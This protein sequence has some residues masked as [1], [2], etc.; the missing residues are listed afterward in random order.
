M[1]ADIHSVAAGQKGSEGLGGGTSGLGFSPLPFPWWNPIL[2]L[3][4]QVAAQLKVNLEPAGEVGKMQ[5]REG[6]KPLP[7]PACLLE[8]LAS[9]AQPL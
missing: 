4:G 3:G 8:S 1:E 6:R 7:L 2:P 5:I 9:P